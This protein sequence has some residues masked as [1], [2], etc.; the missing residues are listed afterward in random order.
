MSHFQKRHYEAIA[1]VIQVLACGDQSTRDYIARE[2]ADMLQQDNPQFTRNRFLLACK[3]GSNVRAR[4]AHLR[5]VLTPPSEQGFGRK[6]ADRI[7]GYDR[8]DLGESPDF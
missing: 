7:D 4:T 1:Q 6:T 8:D 3:P 2:F 5:D